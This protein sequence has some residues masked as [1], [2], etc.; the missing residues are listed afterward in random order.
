MTLIFE[1]FGPTYEVSTRPGPRAPFVPPADVVADQE[2][3]TLVMDVPGLKADDLEIELDGNRLTIRGER[4]RLRLAEEFDANA[5]E[6]SIARGVLTLRIPLSKA[7]V[8][9]RVDIREQQREP[10]ATSLAS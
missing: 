6:G 1:P 4:K 5:I 3:I 2:G 9:N 8:T 10:E 7:H